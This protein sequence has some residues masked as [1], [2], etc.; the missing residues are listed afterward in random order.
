MPLSSAALLVA[1]AGSVGV[2]HTIAP[3]H[4][5]PIAL[6]ARQRG[7]S[8]A[9][10]ARTA[11]GAGFG[12]TASTLAIGLVVWLVSAAVAVRFAGAL[13]LA[14]GVALVGFGSW[15][16][17]ASLREHRVQHGE[18][19]H[20]HFGHA[21]VHRHPDGLQHVHWHEHHAEDWHVAG[22]G[23]AA[24]AHEHAHSTSSR[25]ALLLILGSSPSIEVLPAFSAAAP[26]GAALLAAMALVFAVATIGTYVAMCAASSAGVRRLSLGPLERYGEALSGVVI[27]V[28]G[29]VFLFWGMKG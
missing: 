22:G 6:L 20:A 2:L 14:A 15:I 10:T 29:A 12:H 23:V 21:H 8:A 9:Q 7:W 28:V 11:A 24:L 5:A 26:Q 4:W 25:T 1:A 16:A 27:A 17:L 18:G 13:N 19:G 3:D